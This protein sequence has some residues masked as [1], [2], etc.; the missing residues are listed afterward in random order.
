MITDVDVRDPAHMRVLRTLDFDGGY[1]AARLVGPAV[2][3]VVIS[4]LGLDLPSSSP[5]PPAPPQ[6]RR[7][8]PG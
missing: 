3:L 6:T 7:V 8:R 5:A 1:L 4:P 2:R